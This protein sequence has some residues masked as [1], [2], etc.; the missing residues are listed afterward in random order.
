MGVVTC[1]INR[2]RTKHARAKSSRHASNDNTNT[3]ANQSTS[4]KPMDEN[5]S[6]RPTVITTTAHTGDGNNGKNI[7]D[8]ISKNININ[9]IKSN[10][11][12]NKLPTVSHTRGVTNMTNSIENNNLPKTTPVPSASARTP[13]VASTLA[14]LI[15]NGHLGPHYG[16]EIQQHPQLQPQYDNPSSADI[17]LSSSSCSPRFKQLAS[18]QPNICTAGSSSNNHASTT[19]NPIPGNFRL[20]Q[21]K[22]KFPGQQHTHTSQRT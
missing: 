15:Q 14:V 19:T 22:N 4:N 8:D 16:R 13:Y 21:S 5:N 3:S 18:N 10:T 1:S 7:S 2:F 6:R 20:H 9:N 17:S 11:K 12:A